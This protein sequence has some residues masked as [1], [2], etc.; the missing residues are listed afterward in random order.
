M[1]QMTR[2]EIA[3]LILARLPDNAAR[4]INPE[5]LRDVVSAIADSALFPGRRP[6]HRR[7]RGAARPD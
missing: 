6:R 3:A 4:F 5:R 1:A 7:L 2:E